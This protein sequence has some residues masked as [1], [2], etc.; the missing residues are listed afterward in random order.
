[1]SAGRDPAEE[2][3]QLLE[4]L[5]LEYDELETDSDLVRSFG[6]REE[7][8]RDTIEKIEERKGKATELDMEGV[9]SYRYL[10]SAATTKVRELDTEKDV[11]PI[12]AT[13]YLDDE[14]SE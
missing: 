1:M 11:V 3:R 7:P 5:G 10:V 14:E 2:V 8:G 9:E 12:D 6:L 4:S 13:V